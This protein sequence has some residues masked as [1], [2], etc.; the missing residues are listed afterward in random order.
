M[1][2][3]DNLPGLVPRGSG[4]RRLLIISHVVH[5]RHAGQWFAYGAY[6]REIDI[7]A[8]LFP[9][10]LIAAPC[11][12]GMPEG[13]SLPFTRP[14][15]TLAPQRKTNGHNWREKIAQLLVVIPR[16]VWTLV[17]AM[18]RADAIHVRCPGHIGLLGAVLAPLFSRYLV[19]KYAGE[20]NGYPGEPWIWA[21]Q[22]ALLRSAWWRGP[23]MVYGRWPNQRAHVVPM[24]TS[25]MTSEQLE[26]ARAAARNRTPSSPLTA[27][28]VGRLSAAKNVD[29]LLSAVAVLARQGIRLRC[30][31]VGEGPERPALEAQ[32]MHLNLQD[33]V[34]LSGGVPFDRVLDYYERSDMLVLASETEG[35]P[36][37]IVEGMAFGLI[38]IGSN[39]GAIPTILGDERGL[40]VAPRDVEALTS[41]LR[42]IA[43]SPEAYESMRA[44]AANWAQEYS[45]EGLRESLR[46]MLSTRWRT[47]IGN[48][49]QSDDSTPRPSAA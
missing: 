33:S 41:S 29:V 19:A 23:V 17:R 46:E 26:R 44:R 14:N 47:P 25:V 18:R 21:L 1:M 2:K 5:Y 28:Y 36:K 16:L 20:W 22:R 37:V 9:E 48:L 6:A 3:R 40:I 11:Q 34:Q 31:I 13:D 15:I 43:V 10:V 12:E 4:I 45:L 32:V 49:P 8:D 39:R 35:W 42:Q 7:W 38:C 27:L 30:C 24:F